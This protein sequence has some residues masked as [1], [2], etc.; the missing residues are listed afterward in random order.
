MY[1]MICNKFT[2]DFESE[3][4]QSGKL[5]LARRSCEKAAWILTGP[6]GG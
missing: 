4:R 6:C 2:M 5:E 1:N 3:M